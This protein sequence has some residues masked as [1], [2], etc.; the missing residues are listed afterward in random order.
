MYY[1]FGSKSSQ[2]VDLLYLVNSLQDT[3]TNKEKVHQLEQK[4]QPSFAKPLNINLGVVGSGSLAQVFK[5]TVDEVN[6]SIIATYDIHRQ[7][8]PL[9]LNLRMK[10]DV[11][12]K[13]VRTMRVILSFL[14]RTEHRE[15]VK[16]ALKGT[17]LD[18]Y[19]TLKELDLS[20]ITEIQKMSMKEYLKTLAFQLGQ[21]IAL[22]QGKEYY[23]K[24]H[25]AQEFPELKDFLMR[26]ESSELFLIEKYKNTFL[27]SFDPQ[28]IKYEYEP[29]NKF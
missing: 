16:K 28:K 5:G 26:K 27:E 24:E 18:R 3:K 25:I 20:L 10:R 29:I 4:L 13:I 7:D 22:I 6:N 14:S 19:Q 21:T 12:L 17:S 2:D 1:I 15:K 8:Y 9:V 23:S 11:D